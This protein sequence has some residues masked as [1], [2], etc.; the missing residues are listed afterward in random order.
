[1]AR[2]DLVTAPPK[3]TWSAVRSGSGLRQEKRL[4]RAAFRTR[5]SGGFTL[6]ELLVVIAI[7]G[8]LI[9]L[10]MP[11]VQASREAA[12]RM[13]CANTV[14]Q[15]SLAAHQYHDAVGCFPPSYLSGW[16][17]TTPTARKRGISLFVHLLPYIENVALFDIWDFSDPDLAFVGDTASVAAKGPNLLCPSEAESDNPLDYGSKHIQGVPMPPRHISVTNY[18]GNAGTRSYHPDSGFLMADGVFVTAGPN[19]EPERNQKPVRIAEIAD[20]AS[21]TLFFGERCRW[22]PNYDTFA[23]AGYDWEFRYYGNWC[24]A[25]RLVLAHVTLSSHAP[26]NYRLPFSYEERGAASPPAGSAEDFKYYIDLR[27]CAFGSCHPSGA[28]IST[29]DGAVRFFSEDIS[30]IT[31]RAL[32]TRDGG[33]MTEEAKR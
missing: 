17:F 21:H 30:L 15:L 31:L 20:G 19:S 14:R 6:V 9:A 11:A 28:N 27:V 1:M 10:L 13:A 3:R 24:G 4:R 8:V 32:S 33:E 29:A 2:H 16:N 23:A 22:D 5:C 12:R 18:C 7:I 25:S 26:I